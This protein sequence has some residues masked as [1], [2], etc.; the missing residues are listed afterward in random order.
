MSK[1]IPSQAVADTDSTEGVQTRMVSSNNNP[2]QECPLSINRED[3]AWA[4]G[5]FDGEGSII[6]YNREKEGRYGFR[7]AV[8]QRSRKPLEKLEKIFGGK[9][10]AKPRTKDCYYWQISAV[11]AKNA[12]ILM[13]PFLV[14]KSEE[15]EIGIKFQ[16]RVNTFRSL[17]S[18]RGIKM[19]H[20]PREEANYRH[21]IRYELQQ[22]RMKSSRG[23]PKKSYSPPKYPVI[24]LLC[25]D[26]DIVGAA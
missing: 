14:V 12:L 26:N 15:A 25:V 5:F 1:T 8:G 20:L 13:M 9:T 4:A 22:A 18:K 10:S 11:Q 3:L 7:L 21:G 17:L 16:I 2:S 23:K 24:D 6:I 19:F